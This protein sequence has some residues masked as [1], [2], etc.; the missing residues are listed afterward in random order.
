MQTKAGLLACVLIATACGQSEEH[1]DPTEVKAVRV[2]VSG[3]VAVLPVPPL[4]A[5]SDFTQLTVNVLNPAS[6]MLNPTR[7]SPLAS[8]ALDTA[9]PACSML[10][11]P[12]AVPE[13][14]IRNTSMG[15]VAQVQGAPAVWSPAYTGFVSPEVSKKAAAA[16]QPIE[17]S[18]A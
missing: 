16:A 10:A 9:H 13:V 6:L 14:N 2:N 15:L 1:N 11:C 7:V 5:A 8:A 3:H 4:V 18:M 12:F 17:Q